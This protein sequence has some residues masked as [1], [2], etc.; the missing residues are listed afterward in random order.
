M[1]QY[2]GLADVRCVAVADV[3]I[4]AARSTAR[5][6]G[7]QVC[8]SSSALFN[9]SDVDIVHLATPPGTHKSLAIE[10]M[11]AGKHVL[12]EKPLALTLDDGRAMIA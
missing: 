11:R 10:A 3:D 7:A 8:E 6:F 2:R 1:E 5:A 9:R 4:E 12:C